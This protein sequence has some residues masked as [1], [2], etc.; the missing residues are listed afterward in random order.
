MKSINQ[1][2]LLCLRPIGALSDAFSDVS[3]TS[4][5]CVHRA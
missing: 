4:V 5:C 1:S 3:L 2:I